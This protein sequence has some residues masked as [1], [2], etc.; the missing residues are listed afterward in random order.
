MSENMDYT[1]AYMRKAKELNLTS[2]Q[3]KIDNLFH[4]LNRKYTIEK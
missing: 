4:E 2:E 1:E 3:M